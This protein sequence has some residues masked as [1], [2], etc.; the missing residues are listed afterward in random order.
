[1]GHSVRNYKHTINRRPAINRVDSRNNQ[2]YRKFKHWPIV[3]SKKR[4]KKLISKYRPGIS[5]KSN[6]NSNPVTKNI[7]PV[8]LISMIRR[9]CSNFLDNLWICILKKDN[10]SHLDSVV[11]CLLFSQTSYSFRRHKRT[12]PQKLLFRATV[13]LGAIFEGDGVVPLSLLIQIY[14]SEI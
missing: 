2:Q 10:V 9:N 11:E 12:I 5:G 6:H 7:K 8:I 1:M 3:M 13:F 4:A 14:L